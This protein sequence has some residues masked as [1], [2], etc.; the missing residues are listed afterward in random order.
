[1]Y[2]IE[3]RIK[4]CFEYKFESF[5][6]DHGQYIIGLKNAHNDKST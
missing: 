2:C 4:S 6:I 1:M 5:T 3:E